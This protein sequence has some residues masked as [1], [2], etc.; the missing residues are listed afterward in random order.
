MNTSKKT[1]DPVRAREFQNLQP[2]FGRC[3]DCTRLFG[4]KRGT[5]YNLLKDGK[6]KGVLLRVRGQKSGV[7]LFDLKSIADLIRRE[8]AANNGEAE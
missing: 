3:N 5:L 7:R 2:E 6:I 4:L 8:M 1:I